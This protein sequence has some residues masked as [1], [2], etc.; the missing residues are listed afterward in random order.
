MMLGYAQREAE[1]YHNLYVRST[2]GRP[3]LEADWLIYQGGVCN[4]S[5][6]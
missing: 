6:V 2:Q 1:V 5:F 4:G 3:L